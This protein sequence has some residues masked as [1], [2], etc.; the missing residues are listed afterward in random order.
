VYGAYEQARDAAMEDP[1]PAV[2]GWTPDLKVQLSSRLIDT[3]VTYGLE[4]NGEIE[5]EVA[6][7]RIPGVGDARLSPVLSVDA[8]QLAGSSRCDACLAV[9]L[10]L[11]GAADWVAGMLGSG[12]VPFAAEV[13]LDV[14]FESK[15]Q[16]DVWRVLARPR[17][18]R[19]VSVDIDGLKGAVRNVAE[20]PLRKWIDDTLVQRLKPIEVSRFEADGVPL[21]A[22]RV[23]SKGETLVIEMLSEMP[24]PGVVDLP[25]GNPRD[26]FVAW[27]ATDTLV[28]FAA[29]E[30][31]EAGPMDYDIVPEVRG[32]SVD[33]QR[34]SM[35]LRL[36]KVGG[37]G[38]WRDYTATGKVG[39]RKE[40]LK[41]IA[42]D[43]QEGE[44][45]K[46]AAI[47]DP[48]FFLGEGIIARE[49]E[50]AMRGSVPRAFRQRVGQDAGAVTVIEKSIGR[51]KVLEVRGTIDIVETL[52][53]PGTGGN[54]RPPRKGK[55]KIGAGRR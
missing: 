54:G 16:D 44:K 52:E 4:R 2:D 42:E 34:F 32:L 28:R 14:E 1:G 48:L 30:A 26:G 35:D 53:R 10:T 27:M 41:L 29:R 45:S 8:L 24:R 23:Q 37:A 13:G 49:M 20:E 19:S 7:P 40:N 12:N 3:L 38:W 22:L 18:V 5:G 33:K 43:V 31:F 51:G 21:R 46:G 47:A 6:L 17:D 55:A 36:W 15:R 11:S 39:V 9:D 25:D 50:K